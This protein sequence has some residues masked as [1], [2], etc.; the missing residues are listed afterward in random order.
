MFHEI[1]RRVCFLLCLETSHNIQVQMIIMLLTSLLEQWN[2]FF[3]TQHGSTSLPGQIST[4]FREAIMYV[5]AAYLN[6]VRKNLS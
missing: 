3:L 6:A 4:R 1:L 2:L 5:N